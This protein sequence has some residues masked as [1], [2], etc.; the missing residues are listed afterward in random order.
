M[1]RRIR[2]APSAARGT[3]AAALAR[4]GDHAVEPAL[5]AV[6]AHEAVGEDAAAE[7]AAELAQ[8]EAGHRTLTR[9]RTGQ[10]RRELASYDVVED[11]LLGVA[12]HVAGVAAARAVTGRR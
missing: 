9:L 11:A 6:H 1:G 3:E 10:E 2:H 12:A 5:V 8:D 7:K 4:E